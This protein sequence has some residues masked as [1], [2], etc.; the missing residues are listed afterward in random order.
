MY[1]GFMPIRSHERNDEGSL[2]FWMI[3]QDKD[4][5]EQSTNKDDTLIVW[6]VLNSFFNGRLYFYGISCR[7]AVQR[8]PQYWVCCTRMGRAICKYRV[9]YF[10]FISIRTL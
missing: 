6:P 1:A 9:L 8:A 5:R 3:M 2:F 7:T 4:T 10:F